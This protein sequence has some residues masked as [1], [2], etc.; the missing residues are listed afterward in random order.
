MKK[1]LIIVVDI[2]D[3]LGRAGISTPIIGR[4]KVLEAAT[5]FALYDPED[6]DA[7]ALFAAIRLLDE[8]RLKGYE[9]EVAVVAGS[10][11]GGVDAVLEA[12]RQVEQLVNTYHPD[13]LV[14]VT[15]GS[16]DEALV[17]AISSLAPIIAV[18]RVVVK[19]HRG[20]EETYMLFAKYIQ[21]ALT[22]PRFARLFLGVPGVVLVVFSAL[23]LLGMLRQAI[24]VG[25]L[26]AGLA[27]MVRGFD[28]EDRLMQALTETPVTI[29]AYSTAAITAIIAL[30]LIVSQLH[31]EEQLTPQLLA[32]LI[33]NVT[34]LL[35]F[36]ATIAILG[37]AASKFVSGKL[38]L[39]REIVALTI[40]I[41]AA[42]L[43]NTVSSALEKMETMSVSEFIRALA[44][45]GFS[46]Y[47]IG[48]IIAV[49]VTWRAA[50]AFERFIAQTSSHETDKKE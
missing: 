1:I 37:H 46:L 20:V 16:E 39:Y 26:I 11:R 21:K 49:A 43:L 36:S 35:G 23:A 28:L 4:E 8:M 17:P 19:Q 25:L 7:N 41:V 18:K 34:S 45:S 42:V 9:A 30:A 48:S 10:Q 47:A 32:S 12:R 6:S 44:A 2:D 38:G 24:L 40:V 50:K 33:R 5:R 3:D 29:V 31:S 14:L 22:E 27:M 13:G 15:D